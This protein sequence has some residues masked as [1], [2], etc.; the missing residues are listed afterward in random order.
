MSG[1]YKPCGVELPHRDPNMSRRSYFIVCYCVD[2]SRELARHTIDQVGE[3]SDSSLQSDQMPLRVLTL[4]T[5]DL[6]ITACTAKGETARGET[7]RS[8][9]RM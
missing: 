3:N 6:T 2:V 8:L 5:K 9:L 4:S 7:V 1:Q